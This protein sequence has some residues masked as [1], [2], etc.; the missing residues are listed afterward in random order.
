MQGQLA[1]AVPHAEHREIVILVPASKVLRLNVKIPL[2]GNARIRQ[3]LPFALEEQ[4]AGDIDKQHFAFSKKDA[5]GQLPVAVVSRVQLR[6]WL[7]LLH[8]HQLV[9][10]AIYSESDALTVAPATARVL[11]DNNQVI[12]SDPAGEITVADESAMATLLDLFLDH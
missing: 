3:A 2:K 1:E 5:Q 11:L 6:H 4:L 10:A 12:I 9:P 8:Q 7:E